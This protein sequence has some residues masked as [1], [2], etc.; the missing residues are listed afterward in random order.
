MTMPQTPRQRANNERI[1]RTPFADI[2]PL[3]VT[4]L[5]RKGRTRQ[6]LD[7]SI[8]WLTGFDDATLAEHLADGTTVRGFFEAAEL[9]PGAAAITGV[10]CGVRIAD[11]TD[12]LMRRVRIL[13]KIVDDLARGR[14]LE[15]VLT[16]QS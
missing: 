5:E 6:E 11:I 7:T 9:N 10:V 14:P 4:K 1:G 8:E 12:P 3:Y 15:R 16:T 2:Y 13:D